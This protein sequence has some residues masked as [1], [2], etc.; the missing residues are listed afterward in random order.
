MTR[1]SLFRLAASAAAIPA[2]SMIGKAQPYPIK[3]VR[4]I[5]PFPRGGSADPIARVL[6][7]RLAHLWRREVLVENRDGDS[8]NIAAREVSQSPPDGYTLFI[9]GRSLTTNPFVY[10]STVDPIADLS[11]VTQICSF[12]NV[13]IVPNSLPVKTVAEFIDQARAKRGKVT[14]ASSGTGASPHLTGE[15]FRRMAQVDMTHVPYRGVGPALNDVISGR[16]DVMFPTMPPVLTQIR[17]KTVR[18]LGVTSPTRSPFTPNIP[19]IAEAG[20][21]GFEMSDGY[22]LLLPPKAPTEIVARLHNDAIA[23]LAHPESRKKLEELATSAVT[24]TPA[25]FAALLKSEMDKWGPIVK[26]LGIKPD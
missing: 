2:M 11:P 24:S 21:R 13:M 19:T 5:V 6:A 9:G 25:E 7:H 10:S 15:L 16:V 1:R 18:P 4:L 3:P 12:T 20:T 26:D 8:G 23:A 17:N 22:G 14:F